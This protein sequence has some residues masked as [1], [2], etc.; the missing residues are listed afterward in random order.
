MYSARV[1]ISE[2]MAPTVSS[3]AGALWEG[4]LVSGTIPITFG[5]TDG[6]G[7]REQAVQTAG[8]QT[9]V[10]SSQ[11]CDFAVQP[12]CP[13]SPDATLHVDTTKVPDGTQAFR[14]V[15]TDAAGNGQV[16]T[17]P[18]VTVDNLGPP[19]PVGLTA[20]ATV[21]SN[22][23]ALSWSNPANP[24][25]PVT[26]AM[27]QL[28]STSCSA[29]SSVNAFGGAQLTTPGPGVYVARVWLVDA[30]GR[31]GAHNAA[32]AAVTVPSS[33]SPPPPPPADAHEDCR[34]A[35]WPSAA[36]DGHGRR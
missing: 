24:P 11:S 33:V 4:G 23:L 14:L 36:C 17:S 15:V 1:T 7:I 30:A 5:A 2:N 25:A 32:S 21:G 27:A 9:V 28:C 29:P 22:A 34:G 13:Q 19:P 20:A 26:G 12:P 6:S 31:G 18:P 8:G 10:A 3:V 35:A 16:V